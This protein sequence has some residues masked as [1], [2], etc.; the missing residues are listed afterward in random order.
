MVAD[1]FA[2][3]GGSGGGRTEGFEPAFGVQLQRGFQLEVCF[4]QGSVFEFESPEFFYE[5]S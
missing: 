1:A 3:R 5:V 4:E 2:V